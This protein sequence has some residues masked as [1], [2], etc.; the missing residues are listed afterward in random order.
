M[1]NIID[2][3]ELY[4][5]LKGNCEYCHHPAH[6]YHSCL[7]EAC[8]NCTECGCATCKAETEKNLGYN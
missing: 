1:E 6:C 2:D 5:R 7:D 4:Y 3:N 8:D